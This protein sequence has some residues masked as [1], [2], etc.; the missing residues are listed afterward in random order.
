MTLKDL[1]VRGKSKVG[2]QPQ[3]ILAAGSASHHH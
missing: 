3:G 1:Q 2:G